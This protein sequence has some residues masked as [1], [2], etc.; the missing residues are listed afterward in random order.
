MMKP[1]K[2]SHGPGRPPEHCFEDD[3][4]ILLAF[5]RYGAVSGRRDLMEVLSLDQGQR[6]QGSRNAHRA[7]RRRCRGRLCRGKRLRRQAAAHRRRSPLLAKRP[8]LTTEQANAY[9]EALDRL[10]I[11][12]D[13]ERRAALERAVYPKGYRH[14]ASIQERMTTGGELHA[15]EVCATSIVR[16]RGVQKEDSASDDRRDQKQGQATRRHLLIRQ[17]E[18]NWKPHERAE[19]RCPLGPASL[20]RNLAGRRL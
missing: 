7:Q 14:P 2:A 16:A 12:R 1:S 10:G 15:L 20:Q 4:N 3:L 11:P 18:P 9:C 5:A 17:Q 13:D 6:K 8:R 19:A